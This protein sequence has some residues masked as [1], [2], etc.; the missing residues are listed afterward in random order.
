MTQSFLWEDRAGTPNSDRETGRTFLERNWILKDKKDIVAEVT[1]LWE[2]NGKLV[3]GKPVIVLDWEQRDRGLRSAPITHLAGPQCLSYWSG[4][5][6]PDDSTTPSSLMLYNRVWAPSVPRCARLVKR[7][8]RK[9]AYLASF[10]VL[11]FFSFIISS[12]HLST[13]LWMTSVA[14]CKTCWCDKK[15]IEKNPL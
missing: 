5:V 6:D 15:L 8:P 2:N 13:S 7:N 1:E 9:R 12:T 10:S 11:M 4:R 3:D 14:F